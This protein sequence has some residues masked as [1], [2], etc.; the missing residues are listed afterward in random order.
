MEQI[1]EFLKPEYYFSN[2]DKYKE[3][4]EGVNFVWEAIPKISEFVRKKTEEA[5]EKIIIGE[6]T[7]ISDGAV[8]EG[9][10]LIGRNCQIRPGAYIRE[11]VVIYD[12]CIIRG[13]IKNSLMME[14][15]A[16][17]HWPYIGDS[18]IGE[19]ANL[20]ARTTL[21]NLKVN[22]SNVKIKIGDIIHD[23]KLS[24]FGAV[25]GDRVSTG[26]HCETNPG[27]L[28]GPGVMIYPSATIGPGFFKKNH[29][30]KYKPGIEVVE[31]V[32]RK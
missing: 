4:F 25:L 6:G 7:K 26:C 29:I 9:P 12:G 24:K 3:I 16:A 5:G 13:E 2:L 30:I 27:T 14:N 23:T 11:N 1:P 21:S 20:G 17:A 22:P 8:I 32:E 28:I 31:I 10:C 19:N 18:I 15:S